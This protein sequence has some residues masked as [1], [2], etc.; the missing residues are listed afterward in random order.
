[1]VLVMPVVCAV[2]VVPPFVVWRTTPPVVQNQPLLASTN[3]T[4]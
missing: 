1:M 4:P 2:Q 3:D